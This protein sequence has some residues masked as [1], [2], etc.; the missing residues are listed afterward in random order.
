MHQADKQGAAMLAVFVLM[1]AFAVVAF[2]GM[3]MGVEMPYVAMV[4]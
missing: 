4:V 2:T 3:G 1:P